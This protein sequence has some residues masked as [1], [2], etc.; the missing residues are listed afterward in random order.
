MKQYVNEMVSKLPVDEA[1][2]AIT[3]LTDEEAR[4]FMRQYKKFAFI[5]G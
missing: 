3:S 4:E 5:C 1:Q 2:S